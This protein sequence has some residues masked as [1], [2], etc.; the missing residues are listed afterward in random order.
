M[1]TLK[2]VA[3]ESGLTVTTVSRVL[4]DRGYISSEAKEK[5]KEAM[6][7]L[8]YQ[9]NEVARSL[10]KQSTNTI[11]VIVPHINHPY[12]AKLISYLEHQ[13]Y[14]NG[15]KILLFN[16]KEKHSKEKEYL[17]MCSGNRVSGI[18]L[19]SGDIELNEFDSFDIPL[20]TIERYAQ[21]TIAS[22]ECDN[23][24]GGEL[25]ATHLIE[26]HCKH[27]MYF[28]KVNETAMP[29]DLRAEGFRKICESSKVIHKE[30]E[31]KETQSG[32]I[33]YRSE[34]AKI[35]MVNPETD[36]IFVN[37]DVLAAQF[38][39]VCASM[40]IKVPD[41]M[42]IIGFDDADICELTSPALT[43]IHQPLAEM[44][45]TAIEF[46]LHAKEGML[47]PSRTIL[48]VNLVKRE[49]TIER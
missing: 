42:K 7:K 21:N 45:K 39:Q 8:N 2:D 26:C 18:I 14:I 1:S 6:L 13:A 5:V 4:N 31:T 48:P 44:A 20:I 33:D 41:Q 32:R 43:T 34:I 38:L 3:K 10:S 35:L 22:I 37:S 12:F 16:S 25:A 36:G 47:I 49:T 46:L 23:F 28:G 40:H 19:C 15:Q 17:E 9:P 11:G 24:S 27:L 29:A 30:I